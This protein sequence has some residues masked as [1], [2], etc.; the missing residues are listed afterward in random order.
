V[1][2]EGARGI[3]AALTIGKPNRNNDLTNDNSPSPDREP[4]IVEFDCEGCGV[5]VI[6]FGITARPRHGFCA[7][8]A[9]LTEFIDPSELDRVRRR[10]GLSQQDR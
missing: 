9:W 4:G 8:C 3:D 6:A 5:H 2:Y 7:V 10:L 1:R